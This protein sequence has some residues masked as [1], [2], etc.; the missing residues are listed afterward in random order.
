MTAFMRPVREADFDQILALAGQA[1]GGMTN[2]PSDANA[3]RPRIKFAS[4][5]FAKGA[6]KPGGEIYLLVLEKDGAVLG[7]S[8]VFSSVGLESGFVN[9]K[10]NHE[11]YFSRE[12]KKRSMRR[13][14]VP[15]HD[16]TMRAEV[17]MLFISPK[18]RG[19]GLG[20]LLARSRYLFIAQSPSIIADHI[21]AELRGWRAPDGSQPFWNAIG[22]RF[23]DM[24]FEEAD[25]ANA[26]NGNQFIEDMMP[27]YPVYIELM[28]PD[29][30]DCIG[31]PHDSA[32]P[33]LKMLFEEGF[34][35]NDY[36]DVF[37]GG[38][39]VDAR[40]K[41]LKTVKESRVV[42]VAE[43]ADKVEAPAALLASGAVAAFRATKAA[44]KLDGDKISI[45]RATAAVLNADKG[46][47]IR[48]AAW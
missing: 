15:T 17:G 48:W 45:D 32:Q 4:D 10:I 26:A 47:K 27:R 22:R 30:R 37:D 38:P 28:P 33:A 42:T 13:V 16:F 44:A 7:T 8:G 19:G 11:F 40:V 31:K 43:I 1:G 6:T 41:D 21:C 35:F 39:L 2:L 25:A 23:F 5:S 20:K 14:L 12:L 36:V 18:A 3:L 29:A 34:V 46:S 9:Y 24:E